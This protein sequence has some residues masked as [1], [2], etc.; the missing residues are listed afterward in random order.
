M[1]KLDGKTMDLVQQNINKL[2][3]LFP[4]AVTEAKIDFDRLRLLLGDEVD[5]GKEKY[6]FTWP[7]KSECIRLSQ[8]QSTG[9]LR[10]DKESRRIGILPKTF[11]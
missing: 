3:K 10:P 7:G 4:E 9:T 11:T 5:S 2:K 6:E 1:D 8:Q